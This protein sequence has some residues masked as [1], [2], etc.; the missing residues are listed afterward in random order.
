MCLVDST[1]QKLAK[2]P[3]FQRNKLLPSSVSPSP[4]TLSDRPSITLSIYIYCLIYYM[5][6]GFE[7][8]VE[9]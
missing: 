8:E 6:R 3:A 9:V 7:G 5:P 4:K 1:V 2:F